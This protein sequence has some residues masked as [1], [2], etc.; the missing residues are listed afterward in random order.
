MDPYYLAFRANEFGVESNVILSSRSTNNAMSTFVVEKTQRL[1]LES[2]SSFG[3]S[4]ILWL[5]ATFKE[6]CSDL[7]NSKV[8]DL[9]DRFLA[10]GFDVFVCDPVAD[11][12]ELLDQY[13]NVLDV[14]EL[15]DQKFDAAI[16]AVPHRCFVELS[17]SKFW[18]VLTSDGK[19]IDLKAAFDKADSD[20]RL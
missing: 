10:E 19:F 3:G 4:R 6:N 11:S 7:R 9:S 2:R 15:S 18:D 12:V 5:G 13:K 8:L 16:M 1:L 17:P 20:W 14:S